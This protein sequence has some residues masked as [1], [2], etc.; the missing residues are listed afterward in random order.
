M[1]IGGIMSVSNI[2]IFFFAAF[3]LAFSF[4]NDAE[5]AACTVGTD[6][7][8]DC[9]RT[10]AATTACQTKYPGVVI[11]SALL[12][13]EDFESRDFYENTA[14]SFIA[15][16][17]G[18]PG[19]RGGNSRWA[20]RYNNGS[21]T[22]FRSSDPTPRLGNACTY[23][24]CVG[25][26]E[27]CSVRQGNTITSGLGADCWGPNNNTRS[28]IDIQRSNDYRDEIQSLNLTG[29]KGAT[30]DLG[31]GNQ[32]FAYR[33]AAGNTSGTMGGPR[34]KSVTELGLT[35]ALGYSSNIPNSGIFG[36]PWK[37]DEWGGP[38]SGNGVWEHWNLGITGVGN[39]AQWPY[40][41]FIF[42]NSQA[43]CNAALAGATLHRGRADC[44]SAA[45]RIGA[46]P[47]FYVQSRDFPW[48]TWGCHRAYISGMGTNSM[49]I[50]IWHN[51]ILL[52]HISNLNTNWMI[53]KSYSFLVWNAYANT[54]QGQGA[55]PS[56]Q[57]AFRYQ[58]NIHIREGLPVSC[59]QIG[60]G[61]GSTGPSQLL[62]SGRPKKLSN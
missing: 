54:N 51:N 39:S 41:P 20:L 5:A 44:T 53:N 9:V 17:S 4:S 29:G 34:F 49:A 19:N 3:L 28:V 16:P 2:K 61:A 57:T 32:H 45:L 23:S 12:T 46:D 11:D 50:Q 1:E 21:G 8:C 15:S 31:D 60:Y 56:T 24:E 30:A 25:T 6:C 37:H 62:P 47:N 36:A 18:D 10:A 14:N 7:Y 43:N 55:T 26:R 35:M 40:L 58:D 13:C 38:T 27:Y 59:A 52:F 22:L 48:G 33:V 42:S